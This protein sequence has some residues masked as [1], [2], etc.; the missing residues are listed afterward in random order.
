MA[1]EATP[2]S[3]AAKRYKLAKGKGLMMNGCDLLITNENVN[4][5][6]VITIIQNT[7]KRTGR[8]YFGT[9]IVEN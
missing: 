8:R 4:E 5:P 7:E 9:A 1:N 2:K 3:G 6:N